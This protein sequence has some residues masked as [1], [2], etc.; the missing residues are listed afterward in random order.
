MTRVLY[1]SKDHVFLQINLLS[2]VFALFS[3]GLMI[4]IIILCLQS[5]TQ[6]MGGNSRRESETE[7]SS[8]LDSRNP[9]RRSSASDNLPPLRR[10]AYLQ[11]PCYPK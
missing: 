10:Y 11:T 1:T 4:N 7:S 8:S 2:F 6:N 5:M 9:P 3:S